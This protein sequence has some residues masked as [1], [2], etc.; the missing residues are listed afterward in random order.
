MKK[1]KYPLYVISRGHG[2]KE[3][4]I[5]LQSKPLPESETSGQVYCDKV[6]SE[7]GLARWLQKYHTAEPAFRPGLIGELLEGNTITRT[8]SIY[9]TK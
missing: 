6:S 5:N 8:A 3:I 1:F 7:K 2:Q 9:T 4:R